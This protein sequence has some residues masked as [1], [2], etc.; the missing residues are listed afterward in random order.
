MTGGK[1]PRQQT[2][3]SWRVL[4][5]SFPLYEPLAIAR[6]PL[7][8]G[9]EDQT[10]QF[11]HLLSVLDTA[12]VIVESE[13]NPAVKFDMDGKHGPTLRSDEQQ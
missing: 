5:N 9:E 6:N 13:P 1:D 4:S 12:L 2:S 7:R 3:T 8:V 11:H 10:S